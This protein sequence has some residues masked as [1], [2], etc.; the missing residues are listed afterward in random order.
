MGDSGAGF[1]VGTPQAQ[2]DALPGQMKGKR[3]TGTT[4]LI[5][6][7][8]NPINCCES[9]ADPGDPADSHKGFSFKPP[10]VD[11]CATQSQLKGIRFE[12]ADWKTFEDSQDGCCA[13]SQ[14]HGRSP[15]SYNLTSKMCTIFYE[16]RD[17]HEDPSSVSAKF[18]DIGPGECRIFS[19]I[20]G[21]VDD[22]KWTSLITKGHLYPSW[23]ASSP[24]VT[25]VGA[26]RFVDQ[27]VGQPEMATDQ[28]GSGGGFSDMF[29]SFDE[30]KA[31]ISKYFSVA[32]QLPP[33][34]SFVK[35]GRATPDVSGL[36]EGYQ[37]IINNQTMSVGGTSASAPMFA[38]LVS[39]LNEARIAKG[40]PPMGYL[41]PWIYK[42][43]AAFTDITRGDNFQSRGSFI[44]PYGFNC[45]VG[46][47]PATGVGTPIFDKMLAAA[48]A[49]TDE[50]VTV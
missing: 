1:T 10:F 23:P 40:Q 12:G 37:V 31:S 33:D 27:K 11:T 34:G 46:W 17:R 24:W 4:W 9:A 16:V 42:N 36:G 28:F 3:L 7:S 6:D 39:L 38:G 19:E 25:S 18:E 44:E 32:P 2:C 45:T 47:D 43:A 26:T 21:T 48:L 35:T 20:T 22:P 30:Q 29:D 15:W 41:N 50:I 5:I 49:T 14:Q 8:S 13:F